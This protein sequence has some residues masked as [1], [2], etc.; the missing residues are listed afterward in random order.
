[1]S[2]SST[3][4]IRAFIAA[5]PDATAQAELVRVQRELKKHLVPSGLRIKW[6]NPESFH[7]TILFLGDLPVTET[8]RVFQCLEKT[9]VEPVLFEIRELELVKSEL[10]ADGPRR[11]VL[12]TA[13]LCRQ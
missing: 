7:I 8:H 9:V 3:D 5:R 10:L 12:G 6:T 2:G 1:M 11:T 4:T 13:S